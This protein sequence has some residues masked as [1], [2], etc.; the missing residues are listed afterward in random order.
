MGEQGFAHEPRTHARGR[1]RWV[2]QGMSRRCHDLEQRR[3]GD[4]LSFGAGEIAV[5]GI[6]ALENRTEVNPMGRECA[7]SGVEDALLGCDPDLRPGP[8]SNLC[9]Q[10]GFM[11]LDLLAPPSLGQ[12][13]SRSLVRAADRVRLAALHASGA[14]SHR[15]PTEAG[16]I[17]VLDVPGTGSLPTVVLLH[18]LSSC[19]VDFRPLIQRLRPHT[20]RIVAAD[21]PGHGWS[22]PPPRAGEASAMLRAVGNALHVVL[23]EPAIVFGNSLGGLAAIRFALDHPRDVAGLVLSSPAGAPGEDAEMAALIATLRVA[24]RKVARAFVERA[25]PSAGWMTHVLAWGVQARM[26]RPE[27]QALLG[28]AR[29][30]ALTAEELSALEM[31]TLLLWG[32]REGLLPPS[33]LQ[34]FCD[35]LPAHAAVERPVGW[36]HAPFLEQPDAVARRVCRFAVATS[37]TRVPASRLAGDP[38][39][40]APRMYAA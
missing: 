28:D 24:D 21:L 12:H 26:G 15:I 7:R 23:S 19:G 40:Q 32:R 37:E 22:A 2:Q 33:H 29:R 1:H 9:S 39:R 3:R 10:H 38:E 6:A 27:I 5:L 18:G 17:H 25:L 34:F 8:S 30:I 20:R 11:A 31:P 16:A 35:H 36:G 13:A 4:V 14:R